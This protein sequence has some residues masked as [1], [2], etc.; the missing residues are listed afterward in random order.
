MTSILLGA[1]L[2]FPLIFDK[3]P[4]V[5][6]IERP[7]LLFTKGNVSNPLFLVLIPF[8]FSM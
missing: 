6:G 7:L 4:L 1:R 3:I 2:S 8:I 5:T